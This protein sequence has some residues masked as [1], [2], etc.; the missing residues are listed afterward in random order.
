[1]SGNTVADDLHAMYARYIERFNANDFS[2]AL[3]S[4]SLPFQWVV[5]KSIA[6]ANTPE[7][8]I[9]KMEGMTGG[10]AAN[11]FDRSVL[12]NSTTRMLG[13]D[14]ALLGVEVIRH[15]KDG[16]TE[17]TGGTY[18]CYND[19]TG[20]KMINIISHPISEIVPAA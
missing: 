7:E 15:F 16:H 10:L 4:Y 12:A 9:A 14:A 13:P 2:T 20:W 17:T 1:M 5:G 6:T 18:T 8:F 3:E 11:G 19:G